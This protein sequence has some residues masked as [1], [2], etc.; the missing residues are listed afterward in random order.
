MIGIRVAEVRGLRRGVRE[1]PVPELDVEG[2]GIILVRGPNGA[3]KSTFVELLAGGVRPRE[4]DVR[5]C[6]LP[7]AST[8]ARVMRRVSRADIALLPRL[9]IR[10]H[11]T[12]FA[13]AAAVDLRTALDALADE[14]LAHLI[15]ACT[16]ELS[17]GEARRAWVRLTTLGA[18]PVLLLD[19]PFLGMDV[20]AETALRERLEAWA[21]ER[22]VVLVDHG[23]RRLG[24]VV[25]EL[26]LGAAVA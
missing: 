23:E 11:A 26:H 4:G 5:M 10:R 18:A 15:D 8:A 3:G 24:A 14:G 22:L 6:G 19:E 16:A 17:T 21:Q 12:L 20:D 9:T 25:Q 13:R 2:P 1:L 7:A